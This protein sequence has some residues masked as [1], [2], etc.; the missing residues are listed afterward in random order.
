MRARL[1]GPTGDTYARLALDT[2][3]TPTLVRTAT[4]R[5]IGYDPDAAPDRVRATTASG[6][7][8]VP[9]VIISRLEALG[10]RCVNFAVV[11]HVQPPTAPIHGLLGLDFLRGR[12]LTI[13]FRRE[14]ITLT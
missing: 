6:V 1:W 9:R 11:G 5:S 8:F 12:R 2:G 4:L 13:D 7:E 14:R 10:Q 3:A